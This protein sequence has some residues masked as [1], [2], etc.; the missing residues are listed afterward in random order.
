MNLLAIN[1]DG[2]IITSFISMVADIIIKTL[3]QKIAFI[4]TRIYCPVDLSTQ[5]QSSIDT[6]CVPL[7]TNPVLHAHP[8]MLG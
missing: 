1:F 4:F 3:C 6:H 8:S 5:P 7:K 2:E